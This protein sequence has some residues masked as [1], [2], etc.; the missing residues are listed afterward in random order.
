VTPKSVS[1]HPAALAEAE[2]AVEWYR[3]R[4]ER[5]ALR[6]IHEIIEALDRI[7]M[8]LA[9]FPLS[10]F[11]TRSMPSAISLEGVRHERTLEISD[12]DGPPATVLKIELQ[13]LTP[14]H[15]EPGVTVRKIFKPTVSAL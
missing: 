14:H 9:Q 11:G 4:S 2:A 10:E 7:S 6:F 13:R 3:A 12:K 8:D 5:A 15:G 1:I